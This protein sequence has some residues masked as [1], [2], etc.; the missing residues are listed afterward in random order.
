MPYNRLAVNDNE[1]LDKLPKTQ[2]FLMDCNLEFSF[3]TKQEGT[4]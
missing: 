2:I 4:I 3:L 1:N